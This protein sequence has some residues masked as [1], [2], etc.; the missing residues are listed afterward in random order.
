MNVVNSMCLDMKSCLRHITE[1][2]QQTSGKDMEGG[3]NNKREESQF[4][5]DTFLCILNYFD[6][7]DVLLL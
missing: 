5:P 6:L 4:S 2:I 3:R 1:Y 7:E